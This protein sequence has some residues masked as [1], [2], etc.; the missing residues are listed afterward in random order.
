MPYIKQKDRLKFESEINDLVDELCNNEIKEGELNYVISSIIVRC[1]RQKGLSYHFI[2]LVR[3]V[4]GCV[5]SE[6]YR[7]WGADYEDIK[8]GENGDI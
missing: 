3:G 7:R 1:M 8:K 5:W 4:L 2:N 6:F